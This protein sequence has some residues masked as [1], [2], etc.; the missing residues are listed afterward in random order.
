MIRYLYF[1]LIRIIQHLLLLFLPVLLLFL[2]LLSHQKMHLLM[3]YLR[4]L[5]HR[6]QD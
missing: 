6:L 4:C 2:R 3:Q 5:Q 1:M